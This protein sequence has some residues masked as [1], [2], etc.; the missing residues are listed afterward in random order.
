M[1]MGFDWIH[2]IQQIYR[3]VLNC[4]ARPGWIENLGGECEK[5][6]IEAGLLKPSLLMALMLLDG[7]VGFHVLSSKHQEMED[8]I[9]QLT[10]GQV[11]TIEES[12]FIFIP[13]G[14]DIA[15]AIEKAKAGDLINPHQGATLIVETGVLTNERDLVLTGPG[16]EKFRFAKID[17]SGDWVGVRALKNQEYPL[18]IDMIFVDEQANVLSIPRTTQIMK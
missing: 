10:Y 16:I 2:D 8:Q 17:L 12:D 14:G 1:E 4:T 5:L 11:K 18:G 3:K 13:M 7:E 9:H 6:N 15:H